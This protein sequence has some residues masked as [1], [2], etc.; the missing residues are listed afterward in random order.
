MRRSDPPLAAVMEQSLRDDFQIPVRWVENRS[1]DTWQN[2]EYSAAILRA[3]GIHSV[4][5]VTHA[6]HMRRALVAFRRFGID[7]IPAPVQIDRYPDLSMGDL[8]PEVR[9]WQLAYY[10]VHEWVGYAYYALR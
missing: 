6:W 2:A 5:L 8:I 10:A 3:N 7:A 9:G 1:R 4:Y